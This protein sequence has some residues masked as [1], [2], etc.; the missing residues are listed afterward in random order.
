MSQRY[1]L[2]LVTDVQNAFMKE[3]VTEP[4][5][6]AVRECLALAREHHMQ[7]SFTRF[8]NTEQRNF[9][10]RLHWSKCM[11][12]PE[13]SLISGLAEEDDAVFKKFYYSAFTEE[14]EEFRWKNQI[15]RIFIAGFDTDSTVLKTALDAFERDLH[16]V[17][18]MDACASFGGDE[19]HD[20]AALI[21]R[22]T[23]GFTNVIH[24]DEF[25][26]LIKSEQAA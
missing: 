6:G 2:L 4:V 1:D 20:A 11:F 14:F 21:L 18:I 9:V 10:R 3:G 7:I 26:Q 15:K 23:I 22:K 19:R 12:E 17:V 16:P 13:N 24:T 5:V 8:I 25:A